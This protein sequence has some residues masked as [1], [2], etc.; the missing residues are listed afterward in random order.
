[1]AAF[2]TFLIAWEAHALLRMRKFTA[3]MVAIPVVSCLGMIAEGRAQYHP[4]SARQMLVLYSFAW[5]GL[6]IG[7]FWTR[8]LWF[9]W[10]EDWRNGVRRDYVLPRRHKVILDTS[11][12]VMMLLAVVLDG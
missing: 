8:R 1:M 11:V 6:A 5:T 4:H 10:C 12:M 7:L 2:A 3:A 9:E